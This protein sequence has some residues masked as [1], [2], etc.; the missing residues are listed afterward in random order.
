MPTLEQQTR[1]QKALEAHAG[2]KTKAALS[3]GIARST[4][5]DWLGAYPVVPGKSILYNAET[6]EEK[7]VWA[8]GK[9]AEKLSAE[10]ITSQIREAFRD[11]KPP[12]PIKVTQ[13][14]YE[15]AAT[16]LPLPDLHFGL[17]AWA[18]EVAPF[19][20]DWDLAKAREVYSQK[21]T[22]LIAASPRSE[23][24]IMLVLGDL[25]HTDG[26]SATTT[27][28]TPQDQDGRYPKLLRVATEFLL[29]VADLMAQHHKKVEIVILPGNHDETAAVGVRLAMSLHF[30]K[31]KNISVYEPAGR[32]WFREWHNNLFA[33]THGDKLKKSELPLLLAETQRESWG[34]TRHRAFFTGHIHHETTLKKGSVKVESF[35]A[36]VSAEAW[37]AS[38]GYKSDRSLQTITF[39]RQDGEILRQKVPIL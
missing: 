8:T 36:P 3:L 34:R 38:H 33:A 16:I 21:V 7:L 35:E 19:G 4:L 15:S 39:D 22:P 24:G 10:E 20:E 27:A 26:Y 23:L 25:L 2:H 6:G 29:Y 14:S 31:H 32:Y 37:H 12:A 18:D 28:G 13:R 17:L 1:A 30:S 9:G 11:H 5:N